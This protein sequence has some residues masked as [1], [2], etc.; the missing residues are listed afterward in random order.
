MTT[1][2]HTDTL[3]AL[4]TPTLRLS[5]DMIKGMRQ[6]GG[7]VTTSEARFLV[8]LYY[9]MQRQ[10]I[11]AN[12]QS[13]ALERDARQS[14][15]A[16][17]PHQAIDF[18]VTQFGTLESQVKR[19]L[20]V[21]TETH[22]LAWFFDQTVGVGPVIAAGLLSHIDIHKA[23]TVGHIWNFAGLNPA[24]VWAKGERRPWNAQLKTLCW[25]MGDSF[26]KVSG[27]PDA[28]YGRVYRQRK[29]QE[30]ER[31]AA[32]QFADQAAQKLAS[33]KIGKTT[34]AYAAYSAGQ[35]PP[36]H[37]DMRARRYAVKLFLSHLHQRWHEQEIGPVP[38]PFAIAHRGHAHYLAPPQTA[39]A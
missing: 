13:K 22:R 19:I 18:I 27:R 12:N 15:T 14:E 30:L 1:T 23:P 38:Q 26:V 29:T 39:P 33:T 9:T 20:S 2:Q 37:I 7:G 5:R 25:K 34:D 31:N 11:V 10:R 8:D 16:A 3:E 36:A 35:L 28:Y 17:E 32:G 21:Y 6:A 24:Q 4:L